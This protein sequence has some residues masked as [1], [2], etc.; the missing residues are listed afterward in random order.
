MMVWVWCSFLVLL[1]A[2]GCGRLAFDDRAPTT[3]VGG[4]PLLEP[5][6]GIDPALSDETTL[7][8]VVTSTTSFDADSGAISGGLI[9]GPGEGLDAGIGFYLV[10]NLGVFVFRELTVAA[11]AEVRFTSSMRPVAFLVATDVTVDGVLDGSAGCD[12]SDRRCGGPGGGTGGS[13]STPATGCGPGAAGQRNTSTTRDGGGGG[14]GGGTAGADGGNGTPTLG[15]VGGAGCISAS[16]VPLI[17]GSGAGAGGR[18]G[19]PDT[20]GTGGGGG[21]GLQLTADVIRVTGTIAMNGEGGDG[22]GG[23]LGNAGAGGGGGAGGG[24]LLE[25]RVVTFSSTAILVANGG[26]GGGASRDAQRGAAGERGRRSLDPALGGAA[27]VAANGDGGSGAARGLDAFKGGDGSTN[28][29]GGGGGAGAIHVRAAGSVVEP[30]V[31]SPAWTAVTIG[32]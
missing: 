2:A 30:G 12:G 32:L 10:G 16:L 1:S 11:G 7:A 17:G 13:F 23:L 29:G 20:F 5:S 15:G 18:G 8:I 4:C 3:C 27:A 9:R 21:G 25:G 26:G 6:N 24:I 14:G 22:G 19:A 28:G 31:V